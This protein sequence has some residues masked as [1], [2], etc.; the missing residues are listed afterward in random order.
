MTKVVVIG[1]HG[2]VGTVLI[3]KLASLKRFELTCIDPKWFE[4]AEIENVTEL[5]DKFI[6]R[7]TLDIDTA[8]LSEII[9][10]SEIV[11]SLAAISNDPMGDRFSNLTHK[12]NLVESKRIYEISKNLGVKRFI[13]ASSCS[14]YGSGGNTILKEVS[15]TNPLTAYARSKVDFEQ[16]LNNQNDKVEKFSLR[17]AT[18]AGVSPCPRLDLAINDFVYHSLRDRVIKLNSSGN[19]YRPFIAVNDMALAI[20]NCCDLSYVSDKTNRIFNVGTN[21]NNYKIYNVAKLVAKKCNADI[22]VSNSI[23]D[24]RNYQVSFDKYLKEFPH[25]FESVDEIIDELIEQYSSLL[26]RPHAKD[27][28][29]R[30][31]VLEKVFE[32]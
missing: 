15:V 27:D 8:N 24:S 25:K 18:A 3:K 22:S 29:I 7:S 11:I 32:K 16:F 10:G 2:Y 1:S 6:A 12:I 19:A 20:I 28:F 31:K 23:D 4:V 17:F 5:T 9:S 21:D 13:F 26:N 30:L 14:V